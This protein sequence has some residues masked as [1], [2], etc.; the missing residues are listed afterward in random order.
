MG[1]GTLDIFDR[2]F[3]VDQHRDVAAVSLLERRF[4]IFEGLVPATT[5]GQPRHFP[6]VT[7]VFE[8]L[9]EALTKADLDFFGIPAAFDVDV[10]A[11]Q[12]VPPIC[13]RVQSWP[14]R[15]RS[16]HSASSAPF[17]RSI[18]VFPCSLEQTTTTSGVSVIASTRMSE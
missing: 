10:A 15:Y 14:R 4:E 5:G 13:P 12:R 16:S 6:A 3:A 17:S 1:P 18:R 9:V 7:H 2:I 8:Q 11:H